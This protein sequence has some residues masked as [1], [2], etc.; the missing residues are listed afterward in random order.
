MM[1][2]DLE[3]KKCRPMNVLKDNIVRDGPG[4]PSRMD[5]KPE[6]PQYI[7]PPNKDE[8][9]VIIGDEGLEEKGTTTSS[10][11]DVGMPATNDKWATDIIVQPA[12]QEND[13]AME[14][15]VP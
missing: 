12:D 8:E 15:T 4:H 10:N 1:S 14:V 9:M 5:R 13:I 2:N 3:P 11:A 6:S 7:S